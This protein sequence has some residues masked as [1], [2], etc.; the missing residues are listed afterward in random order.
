[1]QQNSN[2]PKAWLH[3]AN[4]LLHINFRQF[5]LDYATK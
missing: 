5:C 3:M 4:F 2:A 1:M